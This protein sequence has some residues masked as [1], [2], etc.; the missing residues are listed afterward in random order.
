ME[1]FDAA[2][3]SLRKNWFKRLKFGLLKR[4]QLRSFAVA[5]LVIFISE[6]ARNSISRL[7]SIKSSAVI[8]HGISDAFRK[9]V[10]TAISS[11]I[12]DNC[13][14]YVSRF[15]PYKMHFNLVK[16][17]ALLADNVKERHRLV[18]VGEYETAAGYRVKQ[19]ISELGLEG[20]VI[21]TGPIENK[22]L[23]SVYGRGQ[24]VIFASICENCPNI[25]LEAMSAGKGILCS[26]VQPMPEIAEDSVSYFDPMDTQATAEALDFLLS[27]PH[28]VQELGARAKLRSQ[29]FSWEVTFDMTWREFKKLRS[30]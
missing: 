5:D 16:A 12:P 2:A 13:L 18:F 10:P 11:T 4:S 23:P 21:L 17:Y 27:S 14:L 30:R 3:L 6:Y 28:V 29:Q 25:L 8:Y 24:L 20:Y 19:L 22:L 26:D 7:V 15:E 1:P 9:G